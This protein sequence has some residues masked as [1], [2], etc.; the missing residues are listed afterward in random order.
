MVKWNNHL[1]RNIVFSGYSTAVSIRVFNVLKY[2]F[3]SY[4]V[5]D[6]IRNEWPLNKFMLVV[7]Q[8]KQRLKT[9]L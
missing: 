5:W 8:Y 4:L 9:H 2:K 6:V 3:C 7:Y 1:K